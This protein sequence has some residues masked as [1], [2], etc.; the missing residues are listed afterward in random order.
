MASRRLVSP[1]ITEQQ[2]FNITIH[3][4]HHISQLESHSTKQ[5][6]ISSQLKMLILQLLIHTMSTHYIIHSKLRR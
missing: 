6:K 2:T 3:I 1:E 4:F 5:P